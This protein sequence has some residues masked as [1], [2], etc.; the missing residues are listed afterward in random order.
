M[1]C[2][3]VR[4]T[5][6]LLSTVALIGVASCSTAPKAEDREAF[7]AEAAAAEEWF[8]S[9]V[10]GLREQ[11]DDSAAYIIFPSVG[12]YGL[13]FMGGKFGRGSL[14]RPDG[15]RIGWAAMNTSSIGLQ[16]G[17]QG[18]K[19]LLVLQS[20]EKVQEFMANQLSGGVSAV[21]VAAEAGGSTAAQFENGVAMYQ[22]A[23]TGLMAGVNIG[24]DYIRYKPLGAED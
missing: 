3:F 12:Q 21:A 15:S 10:S 8:V 6:L 2:G 18:F 4:G 13:I 20:E 1:K 16:A 19:M 14:N 17:V 7:E 5:M 24:L 11:I 22:G 23:N 9:N